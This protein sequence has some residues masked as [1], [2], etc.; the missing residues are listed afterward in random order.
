MKKFL[1]KQSNVL[2][3]E[4]L[5]ELLQQSL[6]STKKIIFLFQNFTQMKDIIK[7]YD[8]N[9]RGNYTLTLAQNVIKKLYQFMI[10][11]EIF[12]VKNVMKIR[13]GRKNSY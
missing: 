9:Q 10:K 11:V 1:K 8:I 12:I 13:L 6:N 3:L 7:D 5:L 4:D 2:F